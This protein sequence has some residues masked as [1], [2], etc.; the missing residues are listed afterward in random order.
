MINHVIGLLF[1]PK[2]QW[3]TIAREYS[4]SLVTTLLYVM[5]LAALPALAWYYGTTS[6]G[7][8]VGD[9]ETIKLTKLS[10]GKIIPLFYLTMVLSV[11]AIGYM[12]HWMAETYGTD[13]STAKGI[14]VAGFTA[15]PLFIAGAVGF[16]PIF[17]LALLIAIAAVSYAVYL[18]YLGIPAV[19]G[20]PEERGFL[21]ASAV[22]AVCLVILMT[23]MGGSVILWDMGAAPTFTD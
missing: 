3:Q 5:V 7:W 11:C 16:L 9:G 23:I 12:I 2:K 18:L 20:I 22:I 1:W 6:I 14:A 21:F 10:A 4:F 15:T 19:M 8:S 17:W 13:S